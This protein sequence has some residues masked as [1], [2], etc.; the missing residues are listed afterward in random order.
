[1]R[2]RLSRTVSMGKQCD[3]KLGISGLRGKQRKYYLSWTKAPILFQLVRTSPLV[4]G[5]GVRAKALSNFLEIRLSRTVSVERQFVDKLWF[6][7]LR[8]KQRKYFFSR[9][10]TPILFQ[11]VRTSPFKAGLGVRAKVLSKFLEDPTFADGFDGEAVWW[12]IGNIGMT[13]K[14]GNSRTK[15]AKL[16]KLVRTSSLVEGLG[17][18][19]RGISKFFEDLTFADGFGGEV[20]WW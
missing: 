15:A 8:G 5:L 6:F 1:L 2:I 3:D 18:E 9:T 7:G 16:F 19:A 20:V 11:L 4:A 12:Q 14:A 10:K 17:V 13:G